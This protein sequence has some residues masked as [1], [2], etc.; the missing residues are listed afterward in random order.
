MNRFILAALVLLAAALPL[1]SPLAGEEVVMSRGNFGEDFA[2]IDGYLKVRWRNSYGVEPEEGVDLLTL[3]EVFVGRHDVNDDRQDEL[4]VNME[5]SCGSVGCPTAVFEKKDGEWEKISSNISV[6]GHKRVD[7]GFVH[8]LDVWTDP[9]TGYKTVFSYYAGLRWTGEGYEHVGDNGVV[10]VSARM[11]PDFDAE[12]GCVEPGDEGFA[13]LMAYVGTRKPMCLIY[14]PNVRPGL[15]ALLGAKFLHLRKNL[16]RFASI[17]FSEGYIAIAGSRR[18]T[19]REWDETA[20]VMV[21]THDGRAHVGIY[22]EGVRT[23]YSSAKQWFHLPSLFRAWARGHL[24]PYDFEEPQDIV[25]I[26]RGEEE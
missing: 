4:F 20:V 19:L 25:W 23:I 5:V 21:S 18:P 17:D 16:D 8:Y 11:P 1:A 15:D 12:G 3:D 13:F 9:S 24:D 22:S 7:G 10:E 26:G 14:D 6:L 2:F